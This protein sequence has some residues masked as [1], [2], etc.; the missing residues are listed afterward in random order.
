MTGGGERAVLC[1]LA[2]ADAE[3]RPNVSPKEIFAFPEPGLMVI[4]DIASAGSV[5]NLRA[6][7]AAC[8]SL[9][10][11]FS[12]RGRKIEGRAEILAPDSP[13][14]ARLAAPLEALTGGAFP[15]RHVI[16]IRI[17]RDTPVLAPSY[18]FRP[19]KSDDAFR[20]EAYRAYGVRP[21]GER[22]T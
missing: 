3:G 12:Q 19:G 4:A 14:F 20:E 11:I 5:R 7:P 21:A 10:D 2:T 18:R 13:G 15:I 22:E 1:W 6:N 17:D 16:A 9:I 8:V